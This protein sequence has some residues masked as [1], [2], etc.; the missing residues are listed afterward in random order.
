VEN[1]LII[2]LNQENL[3]LLKASTIKEAKERKPLQGQG[4]SPLIEGKKLQQ[5]GD[6]RPL[7]ERK[8]PRKENQ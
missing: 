6:R 5:K 1:M 7:K 4:K 8:R 3:R 2:S